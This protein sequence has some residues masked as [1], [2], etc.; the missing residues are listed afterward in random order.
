MTHAEAESGARALEMLRAASACGTPYD[1]A[2]LDLM[3]PGMDGF[4][5]ARAVKADLAIAA[6]PL[7][8]LTSFRQRG[9]GAMSRE[10]G[11]AAYLTKP[12][13]QSQ[14]FGCLTCVMSREPS[15]S[16]CAGPHTGHR[17]SP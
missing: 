9:H 4:E 10:A 15:A 8:M 7:V 6:T 1:L 17:R 3:M 2:I 14:L 11:V 12:V 16:G 13:R 5:L